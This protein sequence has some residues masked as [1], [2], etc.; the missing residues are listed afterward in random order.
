LQF[1]RVPS[2]THHCVLIVNAA[3]LM[4]NLIRNNTINV[5]LHDILSSRSPRVAESRR[6]R[7]KNADGG[8]TRLPIIS[9][10]YQVANGRRSILIYVRDTVGIPRIIFVEWFRGRSAS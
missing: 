10:I 1:N 4:S 5:L 2:C 9:L 7:Q 6:G 8:S 3:L